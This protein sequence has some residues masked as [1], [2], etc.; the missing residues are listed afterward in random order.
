MIRYKNNNG[1]TK[2]HSITQRDFKIQLRRI[3]TGENTQHLKY[4]LNGQPTRNY[5]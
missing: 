5:Y 1:D 3:Q 2:L 4:Q